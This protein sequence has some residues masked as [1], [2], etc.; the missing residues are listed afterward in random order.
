V[1]GQIQG[2]LPTA[3]SIPAAQYQLHS[4]R[5]L[6]ADGRR[7]FFDSFDALLPRDTNGKEDVYE[8][9]AASSQ[10]DCEEK[11]AELYVASSAG[12]LSLISSGQSPQDSEF[13]DAN[14]SGDDAFFTTSAGLL[15]QDPGLIDVYDARANGGLPAPPE[16]PGPCQGEACQSAAAPPNDPTPA[17][18]SFRGAGNPSAKGR[19]ARGK[20][21]RKGRCV[22]K[23]HKRAKKRHRNNRDANHNR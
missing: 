19:C 23:K 13:L 5:V 15:P 3:G 9:E 2:T 8:W 12:C 10:A 11:G 16:P 21:S 20:V 22:A 18:A 4:P 7:L 6:S 17:S 1:P 14:P